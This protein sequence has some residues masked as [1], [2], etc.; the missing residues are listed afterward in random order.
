MTYNIQIIKSIRKSISIKLDKSWNIVVRAPFF[1]TST[2][3]DSFIKKHNS[4]IEKH[5]NKIKAHSPFNYNSSDEILYFWKIYK[6]KSKEE[7]KS[8]LLLKDDT[9]YIDK[10]LTKE[11]RKK[12]ISEFYKKE[13]SFYLVERTKYFVEKYKLKVNSIKIGS[14]KTRWWSC[15]SKKDIRF[16]YYLLFAPLESIDYVII[17]E[18]AHL[19]EMNHSKNFWNEVERMMSEYKVHKNWF[20][21]NKHISF[22]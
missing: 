20:K 17:H 14:A 15:N 1:M 3:I 2:S 5:R 12:L 8:W 7:I 9:F 6:I 11:K 21:E 18:L 13:A 19:K 22:F 4:W 10:N 16:T